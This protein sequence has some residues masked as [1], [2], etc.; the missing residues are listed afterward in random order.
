MGN[1]F[2]V[3]RTL[4]N[5]AR[6]L[7]SIQLLGIDALALNDRAQSSEWE[8]GLLG[9][10]AL[11]AHEVTIAAAR[12]CGSARG[13]LAI[14]FTHEFAHIS[15]AIDQVSAAGGG[16]A[17]LNG[18]EFRQGK[19]LLPVAPA[20]P[21]SIW[22]LL[23]GSPRSAIVPLLLLS[24]HILDGMDKG[25]PELFPASRTASTLP[26]RATPTSL[27]LLAIDRF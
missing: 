12:A 18:G 27:P 10:W 22:P 2:P 7:P 15:D 1:S 9:L 8:V 3:R 26:S 6:L 5:A 4:D 25:G 14:E 17:I 13:A 24:A 19:S 16:I 21:T 20:N 23:L 11:L